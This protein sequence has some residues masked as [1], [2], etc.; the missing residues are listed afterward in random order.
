MAKV[1]NNDI[2]LRH[3]ILDLKINPKYSYN[4]FL[5]LNLTLLD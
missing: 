1:I 2:N 4:A 5:I 3:K